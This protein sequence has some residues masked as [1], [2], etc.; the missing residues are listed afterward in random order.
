MTAARTSSTAKRKRT[1]A[2]DLDVRGLEQGYRSGLEE[3]NAEWLRKNKFPVLFEVEKIPFIQPEK[4]RSY[5]PDFKLCDGLYVETKG[6]FLCEDRQKHLW[7]KAQHPEIEI[8]FVFQNP[9]API[10]KGSKTTYARWADRHGFK[11]SKGLIPIEWMEEARGRMAG[12]G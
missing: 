8:R 4:P 2:V 5:S 7:L 11:W 9:Q 12:V 10:S 1:R 3:V 6:R